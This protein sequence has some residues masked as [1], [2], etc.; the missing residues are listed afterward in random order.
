VGRQFIV[1]DNVE[2]IEEEQK[3]KEKNLGGIKT[4]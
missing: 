4:N 3:C 2:R 1:C